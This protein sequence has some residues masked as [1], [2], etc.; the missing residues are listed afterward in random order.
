MSLFLF[1][2]AGCDS[3]AVGSQKRKLHFLLGITKK[4]NHQIWL[5]YF[6]PSCDAKDL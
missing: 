3:P 6:F 1:H 2:E 4:D 5:L